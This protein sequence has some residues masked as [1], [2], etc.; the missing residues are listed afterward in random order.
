LLLLVTLMLPARCCIACFACQQGEIMH[1]CVMP[2]AGAPCCP[3]PATW[4]AHTP[5]VCTINDYRHGT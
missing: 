2:R 5:P 1:E 3:N 4:P